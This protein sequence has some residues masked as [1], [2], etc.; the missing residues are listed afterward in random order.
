M[1]EV[2]LAIKLFRLPCELVSLDLMDKMGRHQLHIGQG[3]Y[4]QPLDSF[5]KVLDSTTTKV[6]D[7]DI[8]KH[9]D[10]K[11]LNFKKIVEKLKNNEGCYL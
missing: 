5:G 10:G 4:T 1:M 11:S 7:I 9:D 6:K 3:L 2:N 8:N